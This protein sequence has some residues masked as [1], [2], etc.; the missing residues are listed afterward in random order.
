MKIYDIVQRSD[1][2]AGRTFDLFVL[3]LIVFSIITLSIETLPN[4]PPLAKQ[5]LGL[6][7]VVVT[8]LF[9][10]EYFLR[11]A[12]APSKRGYIFSFYGV[13][14]LLAILPFYLSLVFL[15]FG[16][17]L[18]F[19]RVFRL[20]RI[21]NIL[22]IARYSKAMKRFG[23]ALK[24]TQA[25][26]LIFLCAALML[27]YFAAA[28][29]YYFEF[30]HGKYP[31]CFQ[32]IFHSLWWAVTT[33]TTVGYGDCYPI[34]EGG[35]LFTFLILMCGLGVVAVPAGLI[36]A[37]LSKVLQEEDQRQDK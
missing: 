11:V 13:I 23:D 20:F 19:I 8:I 6:S 21:F 18:R 17:D 12:T 26:A 24:H 5:I 15:P 33:M 3:F 9:T 36:A 25:E 2:V 29:I 14:D 27:L 28:G 7:E 31:E 37:A 32:S 35:K 1:T 22:K 16:I 4:L 10:I 34:T 30:E